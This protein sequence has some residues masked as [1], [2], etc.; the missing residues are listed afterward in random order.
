MP[1]LNTLKMI[2]QFL[3][4]HLS[5]YSDLALDFLIGPLPIILVVFYVMPPNGPY[6]LS[7]LI[8]IPHQ[9]MNTCCSTLLIFYSSTCLHGSIIY[10]CQFSACTFTHSLWNSISISTSFFSFLFIHSINYC[11]TLFIK[12][13]LFKLSFPPLYTKM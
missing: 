3:L 4:W 1:H 8:T 5:H 2:V 6:H 9:S 7:T 12:H 10:S 13:F 11:P